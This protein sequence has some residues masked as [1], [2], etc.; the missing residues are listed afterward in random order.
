MNK[1][2]T[3]LTQMESAQ[4]VKERALLLLDLGMAHINLDHAEVERYA[5]QALELSREGNDPDT[6][7]RSNNLLGWVAHRRSDYFNA[8][9]HYQATL[10]LAQ[11]MN[12][13]VILARVNL[14]LGNVYCGISNYERAM[15][16]IRDSLKFAQQSDDQND[17]CRVLLTYG[18][19]FRSQG[20][21]T[22]ALANLNRVVAY[23]GDIPEQQTMLAFAY[24]N[25]GLTHWNMGELQQAYNYFRKA[26]QIRLETGSDFDLAG[27][28]INLA[29]VCQ[30]LH[31]Y[32]LARQTHEKA[33]ALSEKIE[34]KDLVT[35]CM[36]N[37]GKFHYLLK[38]YDTAR[39][40]YEKG[41][42]LARQTGVK[43]RELVACHGLINVAI[44]CGNGDLALAYIEP[45]LTLKDE[46]F[47]IDK[48]RVINELR[49][50]YEVDLHE[51]EKQRLQE[52]FNH[53][54]A[55]LIHITG[56]L[57]QKNRLI[58]QLEKKIRAQQQTQQ[59]DSAA[60]LLSFLYEQKTALNDWVTFRVQFD[61]M[62][63]GFLDALVERYPNL[64]RQEQRISALIKAGLTTAQ[65]AKSL[66]ISYRGAESHRRNIRQ[67]MQLPAD[68]S[69]NEFVQQMK[70]D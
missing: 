6:Q 62:Y 68:V 15:V 28:Y 21:Y 70:Y 40:Y 53:Q 30:D 22:E 67:K 7:A 16:H 11:K 1:I 10:E 50:Q 63:P 59:A 32:E 27:S 60:D 5:R 12:D 31:D 17:V 3:L 9:K 4:E 34:A 65:I 41:R 49:F 35:T 18:D 69:L 48:N 51:I 19:I 57:S 25:L 24:N 36:I 56:S 54:Q 46:V 43:F 44:A 2:E 39:A 38:E 26:I 29:M 45:L 13:T 58:H 33:L 42:N 47:N 20:Q 8:L 37:L 52:R 61:G 14:N 23:C 55:E 64:T 66:F